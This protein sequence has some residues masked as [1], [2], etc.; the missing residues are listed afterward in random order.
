[1]RTREHK[2]GFMVFKD[3]NE[4]DAL[5]RV[6]RVKS[7][8][9]LSEPQQQT[10]ATY[11]RTSKKYAEINSTIRFWEVQQEEFTS[12]LSGTKILD[13]G[14]GH[15]RDTKDFIAENYDV[16]SID[17]SE[18]LLEEAKRRVPN[19]NFIKMNFSDL[20]FPDKSFDGLWCAAAFLHIPKSDAENVLANFK[21]VLNKNG[22][23]FM[24]V[25]SG[26]GE[27]IKKDSDG[28]VRFFANYTKSEL[29]ELVGKTFDILKIYERAD[30]Y[31]QGWICV[32]AKPKA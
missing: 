19:G 17:L 24:S 7:Q 1:M 29:E 18:G 32:F 3:K 16:T 9:T 6:A 27:V 13:A 8:A 2:R 28:N 12:F 31:G 25:K 10:I 20:I 15:G 26:E 21:R 4:D 11:D 5:M 23:L 22:V 30:H 14:C